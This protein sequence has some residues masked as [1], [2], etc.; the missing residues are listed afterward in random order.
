MYDKFI[1]FY[2]NYFKIQSDDVFYW[3]DIKV[4]TCILIGYRNINLFLH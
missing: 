2:N 3:L 1:N 4:F